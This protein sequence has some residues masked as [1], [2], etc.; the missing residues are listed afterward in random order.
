M[1]ESITVY[2]ICVITFWSYEESYNDDGYR[3]KRSQ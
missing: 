3:Q 1:N 2:K